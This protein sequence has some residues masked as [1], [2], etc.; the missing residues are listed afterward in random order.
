MT[1]TKIPLSEI[2][3]NNRIAIKVTSAA[4]VKK[5]V[6]DYPRIE[7]IE[8]FFETDKRHKEFIG[9][10]YGANGSGFYFAH[11]EGKEIVD[12]E[13]VEFDM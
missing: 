10:A 4:Q 13:D 8:L 5:L 6:P 12:F 9:A 1:T 7:D 11:P 3:R 2:L